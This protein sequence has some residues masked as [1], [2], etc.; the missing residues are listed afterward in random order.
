MK[1]W[2]E[3]LNLGRG[4]MFVSRHSV[5]FAY[6]NKVFWLNGGESD[7]IFAM[8]TFPTNTKERFKKKMKINY[9]VLNNYKSI[10]FATEE[11]TV[12]NFNK[13]KNTFLIIK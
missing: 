2:K 6:K 5:R 13:R 11:I 9:F 8:S 12:A 3:L 1:S 10:K 7:I 4:N